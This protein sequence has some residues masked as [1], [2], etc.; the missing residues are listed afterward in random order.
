MTMGDIFFEEHDEPS[1]LGMPSGTLPESVGTV[2]D[3]A[4]V[5]VVVASVVVAC[6]VEGSVTSGPAGAMVTES[7]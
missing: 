6:V 1:I 2:E 3:T 7:S 4:S 5:S